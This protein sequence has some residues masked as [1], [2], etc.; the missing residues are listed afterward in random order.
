MTPRHM[1]E[2]IDVMIEM[3]WTYHF[4]FGNLILI[5]EITWT[6]MTKALEDTWKRGYFKTKPIPPA[7]D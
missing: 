6:E 2:K 7:T 5:E 4:Y 1:Q 3:Q